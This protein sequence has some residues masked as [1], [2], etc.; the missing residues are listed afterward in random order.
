MSNRFYNILSKILLFTIPIIM[1]YGVVILFEKWIYQDELAIW[2]KILS[3]VLL[4]PIVLVILFIIRLFLSSIRN[5]SIHTKRRGDKKR[6]N[7]RTN[8]EWIRLNKND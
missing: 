1:S 8:E 2:I 3:V 7:G 4:T 6:I 5:N